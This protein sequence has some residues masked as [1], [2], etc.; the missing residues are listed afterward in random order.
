MAEIQVLSYPQSK[1]RKVLVEKQ[2]KE[3]KCLNSA[4]KKMCLVS[5]DNVNGILKS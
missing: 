4:F 2:F 5:E 3:K 1:L